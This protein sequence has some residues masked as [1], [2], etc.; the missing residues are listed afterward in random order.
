M[1]IK[2]TESGTTYRNRL[3]RTIVL[4]IRN[5]M[6]QGAPNAAS[7]DM[8]AYVVLAL[9]KIT[10]SV[11]E[12]VLAW[13]KRDYWLKADRYRMEWLWVEGS[14]AR[15]KIAVLDQD[16]AA[17]ALEMVQIGQKLG[18]VEV[19]EKNRLGEPWVDAWKVLRK[20]EN[21]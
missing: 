3:S 2:T 19:T 21:Q 1:T 6:K 12:T 5:L 8:A 16:W 17:I 14:T 9:E 15:L 18:K 20:R 7:L 10:E 4:A 13:E 11:D